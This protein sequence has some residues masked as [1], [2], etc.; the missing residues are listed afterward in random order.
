[1]KFPPVSR[2]GEN[3]SCGLAVVCELFLIQD[4][5]FGMPGTGFHVLKHG[6]VFVTDPDQNVTPVSALGCAYRTSAKK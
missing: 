3:S 5:K 1:M 2:R 6:C 4:D